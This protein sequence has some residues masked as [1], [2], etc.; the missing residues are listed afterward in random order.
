MKLSTDQYNGL[1]ISKLEVAFDLHCTTQFTSKK[2]KD[3]LK[4]HVG[5]EILISHFSQ[6]KNEGYCHYQIGELQAFQDA[7]SERAKVNTYKRLMRLKE[8]YQS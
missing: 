2:F 4:E 5:E 3:R 1:M 8:S 7:E 6:F